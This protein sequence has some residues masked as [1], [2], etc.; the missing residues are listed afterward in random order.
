MNRK[1]Q[2]H[3]CDVGLNLSNQ[4]AGAAGEVTGSSEVLLQH[5]PEAAAAHRS[6][7]RRQKRLVSAA[8]AA[9]V[10]TVLLNH[11]HW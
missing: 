7:A 2:H 6:R 4:K 10:T 5:V 3:D 9:A 11:V 1:Y 8:A